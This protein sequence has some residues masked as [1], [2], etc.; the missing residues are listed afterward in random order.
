MGVLLMCHAI[1]LSLIIKVHFVYLYIVFEVKLVN[2][3]LRGYSFIF[4]ELQP[5]NFP[6]VAKA[7]NIGSRR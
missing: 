1:F 4:V 6:N 5:F 2:I 3:L 7:A